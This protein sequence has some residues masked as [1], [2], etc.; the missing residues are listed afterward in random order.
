[1]VEAAGIEPAFPT[2]RGY[3]TSWSITKAKPKQDR[4]HHRARREDCPPVRLTIMKS[5]HIK[6]ERV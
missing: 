1:M 6:E 2:D 4:F 5:I 3:F